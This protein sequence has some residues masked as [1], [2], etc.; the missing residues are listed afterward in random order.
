MAVAKALDYLH[1]IGV[2][3]RDITESN[4]MARKPHPSTGNRDWVIID[5][6]TAAFMAPDQGTPRYGPD[7]V[8]GIGHLLLG[9][10]VPRLMDDEHDDER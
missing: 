10:G 8:L 5:W 1:S 4:V 9:A 3:H 6:K 2:F 7:D